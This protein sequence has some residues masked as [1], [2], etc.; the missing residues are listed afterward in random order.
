M[1]VSRSWIPLLLGLLCWAV[2]PLAAQT[3]EKPPLHARHWIAKIG[4][5]HV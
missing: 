3:T 4:R 2:A 1:M 5:A